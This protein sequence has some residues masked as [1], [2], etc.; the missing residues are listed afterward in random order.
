MRSILGQ[1]FA[2]FRLIAVNDG[3]TD[4]STEIL[5]RLAAT[6]SRIVHVRQ[7]NQGLVSALNSGLQQVTAPFVARMDAD[8]ISFSQRFEHQH[9]YLQQHPDVVALGTAIVEMDSDGDAL[10]VVS[11]PASHDV[12]RRVCGRV[13]RPAAW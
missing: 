1:T 7:Q 6:D 2:D 9:E 12:R 5:H 13:R 8:D 11:P 4:Q 3:S 10:G